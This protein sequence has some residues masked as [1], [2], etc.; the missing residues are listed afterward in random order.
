MRLVIHREAQRIHDLS[1]GAVEADKVWSAADFERIW[2]QPPPR[3]RIKTPKSRPPELRILIR[4]LPEQA[5]RTL[6]WRR[7]PA[8]PRRARLRRPIALLRRQVRIHRDDPAV[9]RVRR[10]PH[11]Q[12]V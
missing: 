1:R 11:H 7:G 6:N 5:E 12:A 9:R 4:H 8:R 3:L 2:R 10:R